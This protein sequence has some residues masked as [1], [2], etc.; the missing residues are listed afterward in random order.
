MRAV[1]REDTHTHIAGERRAVPPVAPFSD[2][3]SIVI[4]ATVIYREILSF[5]VVYLK[6]FGEHGIKLRSN[7]FR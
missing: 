2:S 7:N 1:A 4:E 6:Y 5:P 3:S